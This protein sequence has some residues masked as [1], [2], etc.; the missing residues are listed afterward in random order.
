MWRNGGN[1]VTHETIENGIT[2][3]P[4]FSIHCN[5]ND[6]IKDKDNVVK[7]SLETAQ[8]YPNPVY[9]YLPALLPTEASWDCLR[10]LRLKM[11]LSLPGGPSTKVSA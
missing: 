3:L 7:G 5:T 1:K 2:P 4:A 9:Q 6:T 11:C 8:F 10:E